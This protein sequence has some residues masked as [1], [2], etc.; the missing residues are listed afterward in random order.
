LRHK[1]YEYIYFALSRAQLRPLSNS[2]VSAIRAFIYKVKETE[3][4]TAS[5][6]RR[7]I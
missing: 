1:I 5:L 3:S 2:S 7:P 4:L 6:K